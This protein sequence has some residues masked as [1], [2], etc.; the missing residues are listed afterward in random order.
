MGGYWHRHHLDQGGNP[1]LMHLACVQLVHLHLLHLTHVVMDHAAEMQ[2]VGIVNGWTLL[3][4]M[5]LG[6]DPPQATEGVEHI[7]WARVLRACLLH[8]ACRAP[9]HLTPLVAHLACTHL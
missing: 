4:P 9:V 8:V 7:H 3:L 1:P 6:G 5:G 2:L